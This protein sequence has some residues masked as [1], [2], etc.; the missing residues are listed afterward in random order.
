MESKPTV[1]LQCH[2]DMVVQKNDDVEINFDTD[3]LVPRIVDG[4][5]RATGTSLGADNGIG[6]ATCFAI[7]EDKSL[8]HGPLEVLVTR[9]EETGMY[10]AT[11]LEPG[12]LKA[13]YMINV[14]SEEQNAVCIGCA[15][16]FTV[17]M[18]LALTREELPAMKKLSLVLNNFVGGHTGCDIHLGRANPLHVMSRLL[19][20][21]SSSANYR[22]VEVNCGTADNAIPRKCVVD[23]AIPEVE[24]AM[25]VA[26][27]REE[28]ARFQKEYR[29]IEVNASFDIVP[30]VSTVLP[31]TQAC[32]QQFVNFLQ[33]CPFGVQRY[34]PSKPSEVESSMTC[35]I[36]QSKGDLVQ[37]TTSVRS[38]SNTQMDMMYHKLKCVCSMAGLELSEKKAA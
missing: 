36:A 25:F 21:A 23:V 38:S 8:K 9:D 19:C 12:L 2:M 11:D 10:G 27:L 26:A 33:I 34:S 22:L 3:P 20:A 14:D 1:C 16:G 35:A 32:T 13:K 31:A 29:L 5:L 28:F 30:S 6:I 4:Y 18:K 7:L 37:F 17:N 15:G 24:E